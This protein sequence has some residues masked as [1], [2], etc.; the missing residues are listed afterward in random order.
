MSFDG[1]SNCIGIQ[2]A[3]INDLSSWTWTAWIKDSTSSG[4]FFSE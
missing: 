4:I 3:F 1:I 2:K